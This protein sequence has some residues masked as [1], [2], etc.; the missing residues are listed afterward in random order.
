MKELPGQLSMWPGA[1]APVQIQSADAKSILPSDEELARLPDGAAR[2]RIQRALDRNMLVEAG[3]GAGKTTEMVNRMLALV[4]GGVPVTEVAAVTFTRK[5]AA[6]LRERFQTRVEASLRTA[7]A[8]DDAAT[9]KVLEQALR[10]IDRAF[11]GTIHAFCGRLL[12]E[13]PV[14][15]GI[16]PG[17]RELQSAEQRQLEATFWL[18]HLDRLAAD[19]DPQL[20]A[21][22]HAGLRPN[23]LFGLFTTLVEQPDVAFD[24][25]ES[26]APDVDQPRLALE[27]WL[28]QALR[29]I[30]R[31]E[32]EPGWD[33]LQQAVRRLRYHRYI[34]G[35]TDPIDFLNALLE[36]PSSPT[37]VQKR[38]A[39]DA[40]GKAAAKALFEEY[41]AMTAEGGVLERTIRAW[42]AH[43]YPIA[44][45][46]AL[47]A[48]EAFR[49]HREREAL[50]TFQ[51][52]LMFAAR[53]LREHTRARAD[54]SDRYRYLLVDEFQDTDPI[55]AE[56]VFLLAAGGDVPESDGAADWTRVTPRPGALFVVGDPKQSIY[57]FRRADITIYNQVKQR[58]RECGE[59]VELT[60]NFRSRPAIAGFVNAT[61]NG[62]F[63]PKETATQPAFALMNAQKDSAPGAGVRWYVLD[64]GGESGRRVMQR[65]DPERIAH[66][67]AER[68]Q[69]GERKPGDF[70]VLTRMNKF[71]SAYARALEARGVPVQVSGGGV[72][73]ER[74]LEELLILLRALEDPGDPTRTLAALVG[75]FFGLD[76]DQIATYVLGPIGNEPEARRSLE[77]LKPVAE[78]ASL[79]T[80][81]ERAV[82]EAL[83]T[84]SRWWH[85]T[86]VE[87]ADI[88]VGRIIDELGLLPHAA[89]G[90]LGET[91]AGAV[92]FLLDT[93]RAAAARGDA[94]LSAALSALEAAFDDDDGEAPLRPGRA[95]VV[96]LMTLHKAKGLEAPVVILAAPFGEWDAPVQSHIERNRDGHAVGWL[97][98]AERE[99]FKVRIHAQ[100]EQWPELEM[101]E[102]EFAEAEDIRLLY[103]A[104]TRAEDELIVA[105]PPDKDMKKSPWR[106]LYPTTI[107]HGR[108]LLLPLVRATPRAVLEVTPEE[109][110]QRVAMIEERRRARALPTYRAAPVKLRAGELS[111]YEL[112]SVRSGRGPAGRG[113]EWGSAVH[114]A[115][116][117]AMR[118]TD[119]DA[120]RA[121]VRSLLL[122][123]ERP[124]D[125]R[126]EPTELEEL[127]ATVRAVREAPLWQR[128]RAAD[129]LQIEA[130][131]ALMMSGAEYDDLA[132]ISDID[133]ADADTRPREIIEGVLDL[134]FREANGWTIVDYKSDAAGSGID[135]A[136]RAK[137][138][139]QV[140]LYA[141]AWARITGEPVRERVLFFTAD[142]RTEAW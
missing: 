67:V 119:G 52:L 34:A 53:L 87:P 66:W 65:E 45:R 35:W 76:Y 64:D 30:P 132:V 24:A 2:A 41:T 19:G 81:D 140:D 58:L 40:T 139:A 120:L 10:E 103:V 92:L 113:V 12:R 17:F 86:V 75:L 55:Q 44:L 39:D 104:A 117:A 4:L 125:G 60:A 25:P 74:E 136:R 62:A 101:R 106:M 115:L 72:G 134:A 15:A 49:D 22:N 1:V 48:A 27:R 137:Y 107:D 61:F 123:A 129:S 31:D 42:R 38:W 7:R 130:S 111:D 108:E 9:A 118:G 23:Q 121:R 112:Q 69:R 29:L 135:E 68:I 56:V 36:L 43:R 142:G 54:L 50:L 46:F 80:D 33:G 85:S 11:I 126:G 70:L 71:L 110:R 21:L 73:I 51:D 122:A 82:A 18:T 97:R 20:V 84:L 8:Q 114:G 100:P 59:V 90:D 6:E 96:R 127:L 141:V 28:D 37:K 93:L 105:L 88:A 5:A 95:D 79:A 109:M 78:N 116:E 94:S 3:A 98:V 99:N 57:R 83:R 133:A 13:R 124:V 63:P 131:F 26:E 14:E 32:P 138:R 91:R 102:R 47:R 16:D 128:A 77:F 89:A